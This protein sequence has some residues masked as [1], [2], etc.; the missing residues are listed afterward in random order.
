MFPIKTWSRRAAATLLLAGCA[1]S[2]AAGKSCVWK[3]TSPTGKSIYLGGSI[4]ALRAADYPLPRPYNEAFEASS[5]LAFEVDLD[6][7]RKA[8]QQLLKAGEYGRGDSLK[9]H[10]DPRTYDYVRRF[11]ALLRVPEQKFSHYKPWF[12]SLMLESPELHG[13]S[14]DLGVEGFLEKRARANG[15]HMTGLESLREHLNV[16]AGLNDRESE[17]VLLMTFIPQAG[18]EKTDIVAAWRKGD[19]DALAGSMKEAFRDFPAFGQRILDDRNRNWIP[20]I[21]SYA[22]SGQTYFV[23]A[24]AAHFGGP[25]G[26][27]ALLRQRGYRI[28]QL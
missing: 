16:F 14:S 7:M 15:K 21:D 22:A 9:N 23:V 2:S 6:A 8:D 11:F 10:V 24:G 12:L 18:A 4:H 25:N 17:A 28:E 3:A 26:V 5:R 19:A 27:L 20:K 1:L 13:V